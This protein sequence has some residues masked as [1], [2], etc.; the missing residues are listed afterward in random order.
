MTVSCTDRTLWFWVSVLTF[1]QISNRYI[2]FICSGRPH[3]GLFL[4]Q[5]KA[6]S[7][8][9]KSQL[10]CYCDWES[11][12]SVTPRM[13]AVKKKELYNHSQNYKKFDSVLRYD[14][15]TLPLSDSAMKV[16]HEESLM[17]VMTFDPEVIQAS[18]KLTSLLWWH[19]C[20]SL[21]KWIFWPGCF[22]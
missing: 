1:F 20:G 13:A 22:T 7:W 15:S 10:H 5:N 18:Q 2:C 8:V 12:E 16:T 21:K 9:S 14:D 6:V 17:T 11:L 4:F 19:S 3:G